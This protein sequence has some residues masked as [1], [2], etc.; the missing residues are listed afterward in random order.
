[1]SARDGAHAPAGLRIFDHHVHSD[2]SDGTVSLADRARSVAVRPHGVSDHY[3][4]KMRDEDDVLRY[5]DDA[6]RLGLRVGLEYDLGVAPPLRPSTRDA[7]HYVIGAVH[8][9]RIDGERFAYDEA[10]RYLK[11][12][13][14]SR[15]TVPA[16]PG[17]YVER[18]RY[19]DA[20][21]RR[22]VLERTLEVVREGIDETGIDILGHPTFTPL[23]ACGDAED[24]YPADWQERLIALCTAAGVA[25]EVNE[26][27]GVPHREFLVRA[28]RAGARFSVGSDSHFELLPLDRTAAMIAAAGLP[29]D[30]FLAGRRLRARP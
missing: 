23:L 3:P 11:G 7:L 4:H 5:L 30:R 13:A 8:Q 10:G 14:G 22:R 19:R 27:Y 16:P 20:A 1:M 26:S 12:R 6:A 25:I 28:L 9:V 21:L 24:A 2:R 15:I 17:D 18:E 29:H